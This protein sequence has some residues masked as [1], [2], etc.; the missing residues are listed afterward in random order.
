[1]LHS[2][3]TFFTNEDGQTLLDRFKDLIAE[4]TKAFDV[5]VGYFNI[6]GFHLLAD[7]LQNVDKI[8]ILV[9][10]GVDKKTF[11]AVKQYR[12][13]FEKSKIVGDLAE[14]TIFKNVQEA[15]DRL[16]VEE[17]IEI[18]LDWLKSGKIEIKAYPEPLHAKV[19]ILSFDSKRDRGRVITGSSNFTLSGLKGNLEFNVELK[20]YADYEFALTKFNELWEKAV[21]IN[22]KV[23]D[24]ISN[25]TWISKKI[26]PYELYLKFLYEYFKE[27][28]D[29]D[30]EFTD[31]FLPE[32]FKPYK[33]QM[34]AVIDAEKKLNRY[35]GVII[36]D[37]VGLG[38]TYTTALLLKKLGGNVLIISPPKLK[39][40]WEEAINRFGIPAKV[41]SSG[42]LDKNNEQYKRL[43]N[44]KFDYIVVDEAHQ[45]R[46]DNTEKYDALKDL[47][48]G[49][50]VILITATPYNNK[51]LDIFNLIKLFQIPRNSDFSVK[52]LEEFFKAKDK[53]LKEAREK[54]NFKEIAKKVADEIREKVLK[55]ILI[56]RTRRDIEEFYKEDLEKNSLTFPKIEPPR[57]IY[58]QMDKELEK[59]FDETAKIITQE[60]KYTRYKALHYKKNKVDKFIELSQ[61]NLA[62]F[63]KAI[64]IK[65]LESSFEAF[66]KTLKNILESYEKFMDLYTNKGYIY[67]SKSHFKKIL[68][69]LENNDYEEIE[70]LLESGKAEKIQASELRKEFEIDLYRDIRALT[71]LLYLWE[72]IK[73]DPKLEE[74]LKLLTDLKNKKVILFTE[75]EDTASYLY[76]KLKNRN[77]KVFKFTGNSKKEDLE[78]VRKNFDANIEKD[79][80]KDDYD[81]LITTD[82]L[83]EGINLHRSNVVINYDIPWNPVRLIQRIGRVNRVG[84]KFD[85]IFIYN[86]FPS[87]KVENELELKKI[88][89]LKIET[90]IKLL[91]EDA[92]FL[93]DG[94]DIETYKLFEVINS[95]KIFENEEVNQELKYLQ[96]IR[97]IRDNNPELFKRVV[98]IPKKSRVSRNRQDNQPKFIT[99]IKKSDIKKIFLVNDKEEIREI[100]FEEAVKIF[101]AKENEK[102][103]NI[104]K[105]FYN[106]LNKAKEHL[107]NIKNN[108][109]SPRGIEK[110]VI[111]LLAKLKS[112]MDKEETYFIERVIKLMKNGIFT[113]YRLKKLKKVL[114]K[115]I[116]KNQ[117]KDALEGLKEN[118]PKKY[119]QYI[120][121]LEEKENKPTEIILSEIFNKT[122]EKTDG[123]QNKAK[124][125]IGEPIIK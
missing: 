57:A 105:E 96:L 116:E 10:M 88:A 86:F 28:I 24:T 113:K 100:S 114:E 35:N 108:P 49:K 106:Y 60:L 99:F 42:I 70:N 37:V 83:S 87:G 104:P 58:Y 110:E 19:Y 18:F 98:N 118:I 63:M 36:A 79:E 97:N 50:K 68:E 89:E 91:G 75:A 1:M 124:E 13:E 3:R 39:F 94:D 4:D 34:D 11:K 112:H 72:S 2:D 103:E 120:E 29:N 125:K 53:E 16:E 48:I 7:A 115:Y 5:L 32:N 92:R 95:D 31:I 56:R 93:T 66:R 33:Y 26:T 27:E 85:K 82:V 51:P 123:E 122:G 23:L 43:L 67:I 77:F 81:I 74:L 54:G 17:G 71:Y 15:D 121:N 107:E 117:F 45:F 12:F 61:K 9:G 46:N 20:N 62:G 55:Y 102:G 30:K 52:N 40:N 21:D 38:K 65:R 84:T 64:L 101:E 80:Q 73:K 90:I 119:I 8:R 47:V 109:F 76:E 6:S 22:E 25:K 69:Y 41:I 14:K 59:I 111:L 44:Y 78:I